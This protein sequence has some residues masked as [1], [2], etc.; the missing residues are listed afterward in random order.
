MPRH[1]MP[2]RI[3]CSWRA[4]GL[5]PTI[6]AIRFES[7]PCPLGTGSYQKKGIRADSNAELSISRF[8][9]S[10]NGIEIPTPSADLLIPPP[11]PDSYPAV[12]KA[13]TNWSLNA[14]DSTLCRSER[15]STCSSPFPFKESTNASICAWVR[16]RSWS[17][18]LNFSVSSLASSARAP[19][20][21][22]RTLA[23]RS[24]LAAAWFPA[25][26]LTAPAA[27]AIAPV[28]MLT[29]ND[30]YATVST[31]GSQLP[32]PSSPDWLSLTATA[33][34]CLIVAL[35]AIYVCKGRI[36]Q[37]S[38]QMEDIQNDRFDTLLKAMS[39]GK[40]PSAGKTP[41]T[42]PASSSDDPGDCGETRTRPDTSEDASR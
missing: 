35:S 39:E 33:F 10:P 2:S 4:L 19:A 40:A 37:R 26:V 11:P 38:K 41:S 25:T 21:C 20:S 23:T 15:T 6:K 32:I 42:P 17:S 8:A 16:R 31:E 28:K 22:M 14:V 1:L 12:L 3:S 13:V 27:K 30:Q 9:S 18:P 24:A 29:R 36:S 34:F 7:A 5:A